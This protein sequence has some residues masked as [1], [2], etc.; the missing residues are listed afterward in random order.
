MAILGFTSIVYSFI[1]LRQI[2]ADEMKK[3]LHNA[4]LFSS[5]NVSKTK[6]CEQQM[7][8]YLSEV[9]RL[10]SEVNNQLQVRSRSLNLRSI[11]SDQGHPN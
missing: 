8:I 7:G 10:M 3:A 5:K 9:T 6:L 11:M 4:Q 1:F 2:L